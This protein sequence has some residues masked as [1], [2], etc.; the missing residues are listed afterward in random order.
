[1]IIGSLFT[2][3]LFVGVVISNF[4]IEKEKL[5]RKHVLTPLQIEYCEVLT[6][7]YRAEPKPIY[8]SQGN[9]LNDFLYTV[10]DHRAFEP[11]ISVSIMCNTIS[12]GFTWYDEPQALTHTMEWVNFFFT[13][14][15][16]TEATL[17]IA[18]HSRAYFSDRWSIFD[19]IIVVA[20]WVDFTVSSISGQS[21]GSALSVFRAF[22][23][24][25]LLRLIKRFKSLWKIFSTFVN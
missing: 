13:C 5:F 18:V 10:V 20:S 22:R 17:K 11:I 16:T 7:C 14:V 4:N 15:F 2:L 12:M 21:S 1:M 9:R 23:V 25:R 24:A 19:F 8:V 3:N 6:K